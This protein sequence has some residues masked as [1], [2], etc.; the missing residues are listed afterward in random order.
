MTRREFQFSPLSPARIDRA[1]GTIHGVSV[2][3]EGSARGHE[4]E[5]DSKTLRQ[6]KA[7]ADAMGTVPVKW[8]HKTGAD[9]VAGYLDHFRIDGRKLLADW[10][11]LKS[12]GQFDQAMEMAERMP[13]N[14]GLSAAFMGKDEV[15]GGRT[16]AR[17]SELISVD[18]VAQPA[19]NPDGLFEAKEEPRRVPL[20]AGAAG[21]GALI[22]ARLGMKGAAKAAFRPARRG[23]DIAGRVVAVRRQVRVAGVPVAEVYH[24]G[25]SVPGGKV[26]HS[27]P[28]VKKSGIREVTIGTFKKTSKSGGAGRLYVERGGKQAANAD[29]VRAAAEKLKGKKWSPFNN[30]EHAACRV[31]GRPARSPQLRGAIIGGVL[32]AIAAPAAVRASEKAFAADVAAAVLPVKTLAAN[33]SAKVRRF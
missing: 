11:L 27:S 7:C 2:L 26:V 10:S 19:A 5:V 22:G 6:M 20:M 14:V 3:T 9:A 13:Q 17:C 23:E 8:N 16:I 32:G 24:A 4:I 15:S 31:V 25:V 28:G 1:A 30:C 12:H 33:Y 21:L 18:L 29:A